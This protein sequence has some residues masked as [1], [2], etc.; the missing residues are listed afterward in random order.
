MRYPTLILPLL[1][2]LVLIA[3]WPGLSGGY[4]FD[5]F[6][7]LVDNDRTRL[8]SLSPDQLL[9]GA[10]STQSGPLSRPISMLSL[11]LERYFFGLNPWPMKLTNLL[12]H[13]LN[14]LLVFFLL[15]RVLDIVQHSRP[16]QLPLQIP[17]WGLALLVSATWALAPINLSTVLFVIQRMELLATLFMLLGLLAYLR[18]RTWMNEGQSRR[19]LTWIWGGLLLGGGLGVLA[20]ESAIM[21]PVYALLLESLLFGFGDRASDSRRQ[22]ILLYSVVLLVPGLL[23]LAWILPGLMSGIG[24]EGRTFSLSERLWTEG[25]VLWHYLLWI[26]APMPGAL[27][28]YHDSFPVSHGPL[29]PWTTLPAALGLLALAGLAWVLRQ[30]APLVSLGVLWFFVMHLLVSTVL[31]LE[32]VFEHRNYMG[33]IGIFLALFGLLLAGKGTDL[34]MAKLA[35]AVSLVALYGFLTFLR[36]GEWGDPLRHAYF[37]ATR[38]E[39]SPRA[40]YELGKLLMETAPG[41][42][43][44]AFDLGVDTLL[45]TAELPRTSLL[46]Y[47]ALVFEYSKRGLMP[48]PAW[49]DGMK[50]YITTNPLASQDTSALFTLLDRHIGGII[51]LEPEALGDVLETAYRTHPR[52]ALVATLYANYL[53]NVEEDLAAAEPILH[54]VLTLNPGNAAAWKNLIEYQ[55]ATGRHAQAKAGLDRIGEL[56]RFGRLDDDIDRLYEALYAH[57]GTRPP[58]RLEGQP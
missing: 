47:T 14:T 35:F 42:G 27:S 26:I 20:K 11:S 43:N 34:L 9:Q 40:N 38:K 56:N 48:E 16:T 15:R 31:S 49:W 44:P 25:R 55:I 28:F 4:V 12:I 19:G 6:P 21:L 1:L 37:E 29:S 17:A 10:F 33:S 41:P 5:D 18:G 46:P 54:Q 32:L 58:S 57:T 51:T 36:A 7:N 3:Y 39:A 2:L 50:Q 53:L 45:Y 24:F 23:G 13:L 30:R 8:E 52:H 22:L